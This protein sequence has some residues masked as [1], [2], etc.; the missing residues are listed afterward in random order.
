[1]AVGVFED[2][3]LERIRKSFTGQLNQDKIAQKFQWKIMSKTA[4]LGEAEK[5]AARVGELLAEAIGKELTT[6]VLPGGMLTREAADH[7]LRWLLSDDYNLITEATAQTMEALNQAAG[8]RM[9]AVRPAIEADRVSGLIDK[10]LS[11]DSFED[12]KWVFQEPVINFSQHVAD[13]MIEENVEAH[14]QA[15]LSPK[16]TRIAVGNC[17]KW[18]AAL[19]GKYD[20]PVP[21]EVYR[22]HEN[23]RCLVLYDPGDGKIQNA[24]TKKVYDDAREAERESRKE[25]TGE[26]LRKS[27]EK[28]R[29]HLLQP[30]LDNPEI[31][32]NW[33]PGG[34]KAY[35]E[36]QGFDVKPLAQGSLKKVPFE[37]G[38]GWKINFGDGGLIQYHPDTK[39]H[40]NGEYWKISTG[41]GGTQRYDRDG[42]PKKE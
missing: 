5:Y 41:K 31:L 7:I 32:K 10:A 11:Y 29:E 15:G 13:R 36:K 33:T 35:L 8:L 12:A 18:C 38:G 37:E 2:Q 21:R 40:H 24:H 34:L 28:R 30:L 1:M 17:C 4:D 14:Y 16:I 26:I 23:C 9:K 25:R 42:K 39:S 27:A 19:A 20:Y 22:R 3:L 6:D